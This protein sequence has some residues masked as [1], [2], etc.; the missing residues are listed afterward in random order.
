MTA[1][2]SESLGAFLRALLRYSASHSI[3]MA[4][5]R[6]TER[7]FSGD[8]VSLLLKRERQGFRIAGWWLGGLCAAIIVAM[9]LAG[10]LTAD[11]AA[12]PAAEKAQFE[13]AVSKFMAANHASGISAAIVE[14][15]ALV[16]S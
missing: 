10:G 6:I 16:W 15:G 13:D 12:V 1:I 7:D 5:R 2:R 14:N 8:R 3:T 9:A 4:L 11:D